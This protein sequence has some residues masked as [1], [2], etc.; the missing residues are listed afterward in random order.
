MSLVKRDLLSDFKRFSYSL[1]ALFFKSS[2]AHELSHWLDDTF[3]SRYITKGIGKVSLSR[4]QKGNVGTIAGYF[5]GRKRAT[6]P[7]QTHVEIGAYVHMLKE[8][9]RALGQSRYDRL[10]WFDIMDDVSFAGLFDIHWTED[11]KRY[12]MVMKNFV[13][14][15]NREGLLGKGMRKI[16]T[17][18]QVK[19]YFDYA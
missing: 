10:S 13:K 16:P 18:K 15:L 4:Q 12:D 8:K 7:Q 14:R 3:H 2:I 11:R 5:G 19:K 17:F 9:Q 6:S 1:D